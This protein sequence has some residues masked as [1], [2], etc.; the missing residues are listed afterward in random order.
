MIDNEILLAAVMS[1]RD[2]ITI[3]DG[4]RLDNPLIFVNPAFERMTGYSFEE[5]EG[6]NCRCLQGP[7]RDQEDRLTIIRQAIKNRQPCLVTLRNYRKDGSMFWNELSLSPIFDSEGKLR[8]YIGIQKDVTSKILV[9]EHLKRENKALK[10]SNT[11]LEYL[12]NIDS[13]TG[14]YNR[15]YLEQQL[16][17]QWKIAIRQKAHITIFMLD[18]DYFKKY[19]D[20]YGHPAG[21]EAL[22]KVAEVLSHSFLKSTDFVARYG[23]EEFIILTIGGDQ[24]QI[25]LY[26]DAI[27]KKISDLNIEHSGSDQSVLT[28]SLGFSSCWPKGGD[29]RFDLIKQA[30]QALY[31]AKG[32]GRNKAINYAQLVT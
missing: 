22:K 19:N 26:A 31:N 25:A 14:V 12:I 27:V 7:S 4:T 32:S 20:A 18:I 9:E 17:I 23:G 8:S 24:D 16:A 6:K 2:G 10:Q 1:S 11:M 30:D 5:V 15:R 21:D 13:L 29:N 3:S 28:V